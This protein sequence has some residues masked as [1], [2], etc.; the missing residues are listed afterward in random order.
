MDPK[1]NP[2]SLYDFLGYFVPGAIFLYL[3]MLGRTLIAT[4]ASLDV[5]MK[6]QANVLNIDALLPF[7][8]LSYILGHIASFISSVT[9]EKYSVWAYGY[10]S[11]YLLGMKVVPYFTVPEPKILR[12]ALRV[13]IWL[14]LLPITLPDLLLGRLLGMKELY[15]K[16]LDSML[17]T[18]LVRKADLLVRDNS[19]LEHPEDFYKE[20]ERH[21]IFRFLYHWVVERSAAHGQKMQNYVA[22]YGFLRTMSLIGVASTWAY[23]GLWLS[24]SATRGLVPFGALFICTY[25]LFMSFMKFYRRF[26]LEALMAAA[27]LPKDGKSNQ[28]KEAE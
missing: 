28:R 20:I 3:L 10:P 7:V 19:S 2:F 15:A 18:I 16:P 1:Q 26:S 24:G 23:G 22:L 11:R 21:D 4:D 13:L 14:A 27:V 12:R 25:I 17:K 6:Q 9:I 5:L 8:L